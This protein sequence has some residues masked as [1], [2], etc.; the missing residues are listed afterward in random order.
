MCFGFCRPIWRY[1]ISK[2]R[3]HQRQNNMHQ[4]CRIILTCWSFFFLWGSAM[5]E[6]DQCFF[7][8]VFASCR[9]SIYFFPYKR[10]SIVDCLILRVLRPSLFHLFGSCLAWRIYCCEVS[11]SSPPMSFTYIYIYSQLQ[12]Y[13]Q[14]YIIQLHKPTLRSLFPYLFSFS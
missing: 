6:T 10:S 7:V 14:Q 3:L 2:S 1:S 5:N 9:V 13:S 12:Q 8:F 11:T 4:I